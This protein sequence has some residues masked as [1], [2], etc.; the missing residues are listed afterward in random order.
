MGEAEGRSP[1]A[2]IGLRVCGP[3]RGAVIG[4]EGRRKG[5]R[6]RLIAI[7]MADGECLTV[8]YTPR[9][10]RVRIISACLCEQEG[11]AC[12]S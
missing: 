8:G 9:A 6:R 10:G 2:G 1:V 4:R 12:L 11:S 5:G 7:G 3:D